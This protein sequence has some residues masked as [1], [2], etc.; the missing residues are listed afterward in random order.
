MSLY[1]M[2]IALAA[3]SFASL[4]RSTLMPALIE[5]LHKLHGRAVTDSRANERVSLGKNKVGC[6][7]LN[8]C[9]K[10]G[11]IDRF[12][13]SVM[14]VIL[15]SQRKKRGRYPEIFSRLL[16]Q[17][18]VMIRGEIVNPASKQSDDPISGTRCYFCSSRRRATINSRFSDP[19]GHFFTFHEG[20]LNRLFIFKSHFGERLKHSVFVKSFDGFCH[21]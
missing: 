7:Q 20:Q 18:L 16:I 6:Q 12:R 11:G 10:Y 13:G 5:S 2:K 4:T 14:I 15:V 3:C 8:G 17:V 1:L 9:L 21:G 19:F